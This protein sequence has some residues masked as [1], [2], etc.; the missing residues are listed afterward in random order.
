MR[1]LQVLGP[2][3]WREQ[4]VKKI[5][6]DTRFWFAFAAEKGI[7]PLLRLLRAKESVSTKWRDVGEMIGKGYD[8]PKRNSQSSLWN[9]RASEGEGNGKMDGMTVLAQ[10]ADIP[11][12]LLPVRILLHGCAACVQ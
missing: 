5:K 4:E 3:E 6:T 7:I 1:R 11:A 10:G 2:T 12:I 8:F 9:P